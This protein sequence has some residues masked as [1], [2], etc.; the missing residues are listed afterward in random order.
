MVEFPSLPMA[1]GNSVTSL[2]CIESR[3]T[4]SG[5]ML[6]LVACW[7]QSIFVISPSDIID[8]EVNVR[9]QR[10]PLP[11]LDLH[12]RP[13]RP[14]GAIA[15]SALHRVFYERGLDYRAQHFLR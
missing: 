7:D 10:T 11:L 6:V 4:D 3:F 1:S 15:E 14:H 8:L 12:L 13:N 5:D 2:C 9:R